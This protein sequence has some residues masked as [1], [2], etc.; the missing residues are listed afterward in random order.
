MDILQELTF[1]VSRKKLSAVELLTE[2]NDTLLSQ[3]YNGVAT[4]SIVDDQGADQTLFPPDGHS[5]NYQKL[6]SVLK[7][8]LI[9]YLFLIDLN[10]PHYNDRQ[11]AYYECCKKWAAVKI[12]LGKN[13]RTSAVSLCLNIIKQAERFEFTELILDISRMLRL[14]YG[15]RKGNVKK[16]EQY[17]EL[18]QEYE[19]LWSVENKA[20]G[21]Y[22][23][24]VLYY[25]NSKAS[26]PEIEEMARAYYDQLA[27]YL[28]KHNSYR[29]R[30]ST[31]F[32]QLAI[33]MSSHLILLI[34]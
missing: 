22:S 14:H 30:F 19:K 32:I 1:I 18:F 6:K 16:Y 10:E 9:D 4:G 2:G 8:R 31:F 27:G 26:R 20:E 7:N 34:F 29:L 3:L 17:N 5:Q 15:T 12:L 25:V 21:L 33:Y 24:L 23:G 11:K 28:E 13:A